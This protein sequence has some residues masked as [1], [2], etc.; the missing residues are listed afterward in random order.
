MF[1]SRLSLKSIGFLLLAL[2]PSGVM[3]A[4]DSLRS[5]AGG[6]EITMASGDDYGDRRLTWNLWYSIMCK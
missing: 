4:H 3:S 1:G 5:L 6:D 2:S